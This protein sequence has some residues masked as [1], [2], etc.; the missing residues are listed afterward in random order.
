MR[1][2]GASCA[3]DKGPTKNRTAET[4]FGPS[5]ESGLSRPMMAGQG[6]TRMN[7]DQ[8]DQ[9]IRYLV[10]RAMEPPYLVPRESVELIASN[11]GTP[12][13]V[14]EADLAK[15][16]HPAPLVVNPKEALHA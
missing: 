9:A 11:W 7:R 6:D 8:Y 13:A 14:V 2:L 5:R 12:I 10:S 3:I 16:Q 4:G 15:T 1:A